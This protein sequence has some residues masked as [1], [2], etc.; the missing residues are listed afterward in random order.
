MEK[1]SAYRV[2]STLELA[3]RFEPHELSISEPYRDVFQP[4]LTPVPPLGSDLLAKLTLPLGYAIG[5]LRTT[6]VILFIPV[7]IVLIQGVCLIFA[8]IPRLHQAIS[9]LLTA[10]ITRAVLLL[11][12]FFWIPVE[13]VKRKRGR[14]QSETQS[15]RPRAGDIIVSN[16]VSWIELLWLAFRFNPIFVLPVSDTIPA[17][18]HS[19]Q[20][21]V[22]ITHTPGR[23]TG[24]GSA[25]IQS[26]RKVASVPIPIVGFRR[27]SL[28]SMIGLTGQVPS[29]GFSESGSSPSTLEDLRKAADRPI[30]VFPEC[31]TSNGR[32][33]LRFAKVFHQEVPV[34]N[35]QIFI[36]C[37]RY[38]PPT[39]MAPT[40]TLS[41]PST[42]L[43]PLPHLFTIAASITPPTISI[44]LLAPSE[45]PSSQL[46]IVSE[47]ITDHAHNE[48]QLTEVCAALIAQIGKMKRTG[49]GWEDKA[50]FL[51]FYRGKRK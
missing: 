25:N 12:G 41:I 42:S 50:S 17:S 8:P 31:T 46:F 22:P 44:R 7:Y 11:L 30:V 33:L 16:W 26:P 20:T 1:F 23:R 49:M 24:T 4:F 45:S 28:L 5:I 40:L 43:N 13:H 32:G 29:F 36:M 2:Q 21:S 9:H 38:D 18:V 48:D 51:E 34:K 10:I 47:I 14:G 27:V 35:Y 19:S 3:F 37:V 6:L 15:W 39:S